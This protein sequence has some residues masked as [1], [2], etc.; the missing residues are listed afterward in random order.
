[1][2]ITTVLNPKD[3]YK[4]LERWGEIRFLSRSFQQST[5]DVIISAVF[6]LLLRLMIHFFIYKKHKEQYAV[7]SFTGIRRKFMLCL[8]TN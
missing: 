7:N 8:E 5:K 4:Y 1:M 3:A 6:C 2:K